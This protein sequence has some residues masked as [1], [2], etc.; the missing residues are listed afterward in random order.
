M[1]PPQKL[2]LHASNKV[3]VGRAGRQT[4]G[5]LP[6]PLN[7][8]GP[9]YDGAS[10]LAGLLVDRVGVEFVVERFDADAQLL[11]GGGF[12]A[13]ASVERGPDRFHFHLAK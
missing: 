1:F 6:G 12:V 4:S 13:V 8:G 2:S 5:E 7:S 11:G 3:H 10:L 9:S